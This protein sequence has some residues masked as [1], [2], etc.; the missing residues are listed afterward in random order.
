MKKLFLLLIFVIVSAFI[1]L[2]VNVNK[3]L[4]LQKQFEVYDNI[5]KILH[6]TINSEKAP[7]LSL[8][9]ALS[10][11]RSIQD[12]VLNNDKDLGYQV[13][14]A[15]TEALKQH[16]SKKNIYIQIFTKELKVFARSWES[17]LPTIPLITGRKIDLRESI[18]NKKPMTGIEAGLPLGIKSSSIITYKDDFLGILEVTT[19]YDSIVAKIREYGI[20][21]VPLIGI[22][23]VPMIYIEQKNLFTVGGTFVVANEN[24]NHNFIN[25]LKS[26]NNEELT[27]LM[28]NDFVLSG[29]HF[30]A[31]YALRN[32][33]GAR[34]GTFIAIIKQDDFKN[35]LSDQK[36]ILRS[37]YSLDSSKDD[38][39]DYIKSKNE[40]MFLDIDKE[41]ILQHMELADG[42]DRLD[43]FEDAK[44][45]LQ[46]YSKEELIELI[47]RGSDNRVIEGDIR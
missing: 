15:S 14:N 45:I 23:L 38:I 26:L 46:Q 42:K 28:E 40:S 30:F 44:V 19:P 12:V 35:L 18:K 32:S 47:L 41:H 27:L 17:S 20:E 25:K 5:N 34:L 10:S 24:T 6:N 11:S 7:P 8:A 2:M 3:K 22:N 4:T 21:I 43:M 36:S 1:V 9:I 31:S 13:L 39:Y 16:S 33:K 29:A 37:I